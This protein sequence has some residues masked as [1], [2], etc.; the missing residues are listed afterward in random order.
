MSKYKLQDW[1]ANGYNDSDF[2]GCY[3]DDEKN[4]IETVLLGTTRF[5]CNSY[6][7]GPEYLD[8]TP[9]ILEKARVVLA[10]SIFKQLRVHEDHDVLTPGPTAVARGVEFRLLEDYKFRVAEKEE[11]DCFK[12]NGTGKFTRNGRVFGDCFTCKGS[13]KL[14]CKTRKAKKG[15][16]G[17][18]LC[19]T[20]PTGSVVKSIDGNQF[21]GTVYRNGYNQ[22]HRQN[23][24]VKVSVQI[25]EEERQTQRIPLSKLRLNKEPLSD[26]ALRER[27]NQLSFNYQFAAA[28]G[29]RAWISND[30]TKAVR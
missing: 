14:S 18:A 25:N 1:E 30:F 20:L 26:E 15:E 19:V 10:E 3:F 2:Y 13:G 9:E 28:A 4:T 12:C 17:K 16:D 21:F 23:S 11:Q 8:P 24:S 6:S 7:F 5:A 29:C 22:P 27:A